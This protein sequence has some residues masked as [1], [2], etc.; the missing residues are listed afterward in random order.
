MNNTILLD[1]WIVQGAVYTILEQHRV[2]RE[3]YNYEALALPLFEDKIIDLS[4]P[5]NLETQNWANFLTCVVLWDKFKVFNSNSYDILEGLIPVL[6]S[7]ELESYITT[8]LNEFEVLD[9]AKTPPTSIGNDEKKRLDALARQTGMTNPKPYPKDATDNSPLIKDRSKHYFHLS[10]SLRDDNGLSMSLFPHPTRGRH[11][12]EYHREFLYPQQLN[13]LNNIDKERAKYYEELNNK[14][15]RSENRR[16]VEFPILYDYIKHKAGTNN[17]NNSDN[18][19]R[20]LEI[21]VSLR[22]DDRVDALRK[23]IKEIENSHNSS[24][25]GKPRFE[26]IFREI[27]GA[28]DFM[29]YSI[30]E[31]K[32][33]YLPISAVLTFTT[34]FSGLL[35]YSL[36]NDEKLSTAS[37]ALAGSLATA[38]AANNK[39]PGITC[40]PQESKPTKNY[41]NWLDTTFTGELVKFAYK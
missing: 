35:A 15:Y 18:F 41:D 22:Y 32:P 1:G 11:I 31:P 27:E 30:T 6:K 28:C 8:I 19:A 14:Y 39:I 2:R 25:T 5:R 17:T 38:L 12:K 16:I 40:E 34:A 37:G 33:V 13:I 26:N 23:Q 21:A 9:R 29:R 36:T 4:A 7:I 24:D 20:E 3:D 10:K